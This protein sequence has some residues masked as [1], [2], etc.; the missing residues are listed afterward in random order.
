MRHTSCRQFHS[1]TIGDTSLRPTRVL[2]VSENAVRLRCNM[3]E[4]VF[5]YLAV[6]HIWG[7]KSLNQLRLL[8]SNIAQFQ[9]DIPEA[10]LETSNTFRE[11]VVATRIL[12]YRYV[13]IDS[14]CTI[15][16]CEKDWKYEADCMSIVYGN[17]ICNLA[18][19][20]PP[21]PDKTSTHIPRDPRTW[22]HCILRRGTTTPSSLSKKSEHELPATY[23]ER[24]ISST[25]EYPLLPSSP[26][27][28][29]WL[30]TRYWPLFNR[31]W[32][33]QEH[34]FSMRTVFIGAKHLIFHCC[35]H[36][37]DELLGPLVTKSP[38]SKYGLKA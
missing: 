3:S 29:P 24:M 17:A 12:G 18:F 11:A 38:L 10:A 1:D 34:L 14:L 19:I 20:N 8:K 23:I 35:T 33:F 2:E 30:R 4:E 37:V 26:N 15:Q 6:S 9:I 16:D 22:S 28:Y 31:A 21:G 36:L 25:E 13:W 5:D 32:T 27:D 7:S